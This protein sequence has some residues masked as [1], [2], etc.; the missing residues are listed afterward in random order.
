MPAGPDLVNAL[1]QLQMEVICA[2][3]CLLESLL[4]GLPVQAMPKSFRA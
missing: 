4:P 2:L 3:D 1:Q